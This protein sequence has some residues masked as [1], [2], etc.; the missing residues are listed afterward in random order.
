MLTSSL[1]IRNL[2]EENVLPHKVAQ[3]LY[4]AASLAD[5]WS[6]NVP[7]SY[8]QRL[9]AYLGHGSPVLKYDA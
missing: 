9:A 5:D 1:F 4:R 6:S 8:I 7:T 3:Q 2:L